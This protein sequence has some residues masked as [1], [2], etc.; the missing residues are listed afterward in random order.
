[1]L[2]H[3]NFMAVPWSAKGERQTLSPSQAQ[4]IHSSDVHL[5]GD[6]APRLP[7]GSS[8]SHAR[9]HVF[10][11]PQESCWNERPCKPKL[12]RGDHW[13]D[14]G[15]MSISTQESV[16]SPCRSSGRSS[17]PRAQKLP[18]TC[19]IQESFQ[20]TGTIWES[21]ENPTHNCGQRL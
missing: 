7:A 13:R 12:R 16:W 4:R 2:E 6:A 20:E 19:E 11:E 5:G 17:K 3:R 1:M 9:C 18:H 21:Q 15:M 8:V 10:W 14:G